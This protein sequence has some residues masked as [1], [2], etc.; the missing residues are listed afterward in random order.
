MIIRRAEDIRP[1]EITP[2][3]AYLNRRQLIGVGVALSLGS[4]WART[5]RADTLAATKSPLSTDEKPTA[6]KY[7][8]S[9]NNYYE[10]GTDKSD[11]GQNGYTLTT[12]P[13]RL[14]G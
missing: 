5:A 14:K 3:G 1:S 10:F 6:L 7:V 8:T 11:P 2:H 12:K 9:Y 13:W 4:L